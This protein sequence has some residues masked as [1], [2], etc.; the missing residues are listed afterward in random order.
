MILRSRGV[1]IPEH[2]SR[3]HANH[4]ILALVRVRALLKPTYAGAERSQ[5]PERGMGSFDVH[6]LVHGLL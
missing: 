4:I 5:H 2:S 6:R 1:P 3:L